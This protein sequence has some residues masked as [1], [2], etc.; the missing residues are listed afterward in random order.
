MLTSYLVDPAHR[1]SYFPRHVP[2]VSEFV[3][4]EPV[5]SCSLISLHVHV[6]VKLED[7][8]NPGVSLHSVYVDEVKQEESQS[9]HSFLK[10]V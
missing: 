6:F 1:Q 10:T 4:A 3:T 7:M 9:K 5:A 2:K 8:L